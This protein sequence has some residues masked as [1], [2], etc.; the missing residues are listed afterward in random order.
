MVAYINSVL[1]TFHIS[2]PHCFS[3]SFDCNFQVFLWL[4][5][6]ECFSTWSAFSCVCKV[7]GCSIVGNFAAWKEK[8]QLFVNFKAKNTQEYYE[9]RYV[10]S[11]LLP[12]KNL[13][14]SST[15][16]DQGKPRTRTTN[17]SSSDMI[18]Q[19]ICFKARKK[20]DQKK[21][22]THR[23][24]ITDEE[25]KTTEVG[26]WSTQTNDTYSLYIT[27]FHLKLYWWLAQKPL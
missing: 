16:H 4:Q 27:C 3:V 18:T 23:Q 14:T 8:F 12:E 24:C 2:M 17:P 13:D 5:L 19:W 9:D 15:E 20:I 10:D 22:I 6:H 11:T 26:D 7:D 25:N 1:H 21:M